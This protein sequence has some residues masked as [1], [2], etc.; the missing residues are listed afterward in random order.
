ML[1]PEVERFNGI[2]EGEAFG[3]KLATRVFRVNGKFA[4]VCDLFGT[5][6]LRRG[7]LHSQIQ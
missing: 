5:Y 1:E 3:V 7:Q 4:K 2:E 6:E